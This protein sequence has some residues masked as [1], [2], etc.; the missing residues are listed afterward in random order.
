[1][2]S[3]DPDHYNNRDILLFLQ[4]LHTRGLIDPSSV[5]NL[6]KSTLEEISQQWFNHK[7]TKLSIINGLEIES[8]WTPQEVVQLYQNLLEKYE[9]GNTTTM[10]NTVYSNRIQELETKLGSSQDKF[11]ELINKPI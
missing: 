2:T 11:H 6:D 4:I 5:T 8:P 7:S 3:T 10:A 1:M 9:G